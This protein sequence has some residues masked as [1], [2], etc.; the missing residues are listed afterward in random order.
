MPRKSTQTKSADM[1]QTADAGAI[2]SAAKALDE[3]NQRLQQVDAQFGDGQIYD[4]NRLI[5]E[6]R[7]YLNQSAEAMLEAGKRLILLKEHEQHGNFIQALNDIG[8]G[9]RAAQRMMQAAFKFSGNKVALVRLGKTKMLELMAEDDDDLEALA[10][11]GTIAGLTLDDIDQMSAHEARTSLRAARKKVEED[12]E[13]HERILEQKDKKINQL[14]K[15][16]HDHKKKTQEF[17]YRV[18]EYLLETTEIGGQLMAQI[19]RL[20]T[21]RDTFLNDDFGDENEAADKMMAEN[22]YHVM[23]QVA[24]Y[25]EESAAACEEVFSGYIE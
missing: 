8:I 13:V 14:H 12:Q 3:N 19:D 18:N 6:T 1:T 9:P 17:D 22:Y 23:Q 7:F 24:K 10:N 5:N 20:N 4:A 15:K 25:M 21:L 11:G 16:L 2:E